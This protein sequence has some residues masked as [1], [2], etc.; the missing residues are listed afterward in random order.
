M[1][2]IEEYQAI[3]RCKTAEGNSLKKFRVYIPEKKIKPWKKLGQIL[4][5]EV[6]DYPG[7]EEFHGINLDQ[8]R[9]LCDQAVAKK[10]LDALRKDIPKK[11]KGDEDENDIKMYAFIVAIYGTT[12]FPNRK[13]VVDE[14]IFEFLHKHLSFR[15]NP[16]ISILAETFSTLNRL[17]EKRQDR[18]TA[19]APLLQVWAYYRF[20]YKSPEQN[21]FEIS[22]PIHDASKLSMNE[23]PKDIEEWKN[24]FKA[25]LFFVWQAA[26]TVKH[27]SC[28]FLVSCDKFPWVPL[29]G[30]MTIISY[31]PCLVM[32]QYGMTQELPTISGLS[33]FQYETGT[34]WQ[35]L[36][37]LGTM[38][39]EHQEFKKKVNIS[40]EQVTQ[41]YIDW[42]KEIK[43]DIL[44]NRKSLVPQ[45][46]EDPE[47]WMAN[48]Q[49]REEAREKRILELERALKALEEEK[50]QG[51]FGNEERIATLGESNRQLWQDS[52]KW[53][54]ERDVLAEKLQM[55]RDENTRLQK[56]NNRLVRGRDELARQIEDFQNKRQKKGDMRA[57]S[58]LLKGNTEY[59]ELWEDVKVKT[60]C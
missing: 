25:P 34:H 13:D 57:Y 19:C 41:A 28:H 53:K 38:W 33:K 60:L 27:C 26:F 56:C 45:K 29:I 31:A 9:E 55:A 52:C 10:K 30:P 47:L 54:K 16:I 58:E 4:H 32:R 8:L 5:I 37:K 49:T 11:K 42:R 12:I 3:L 35:S 46:K 43:P 15:I 40:Q 18:F 44:I 36:N 21:Y 51:D 50:A 20:M 7:I 22:Q 59:R 14:R 17:K 48:L 6:P 39:G 23:T 24:F 2:T 1:P